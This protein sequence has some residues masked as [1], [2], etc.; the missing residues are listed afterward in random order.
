M[1]ISVV[2]ETVICQNGLT[3]VTVVHYQLLAL[4]YVEYSLI[5]FTVHLQ[6]LLSNAN[7]S[8][9]STTQIWGM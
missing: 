2:N 7:P 6:T 4:S 8:F 1:I 5:L 3:K 9:Y